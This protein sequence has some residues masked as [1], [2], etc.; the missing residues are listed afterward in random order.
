MDVKHQNNNNLDTIYL[1][2]SLQKKDK[3]KGKDQ[4]KERR[5]FDRDLDLQ[6]NKLD[7]AQRRAIIKRSQELGS[8]FKSGGTGTSFL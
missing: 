4:P 1:L 7:E 5:P 2:F 6:V 8:R 3:E